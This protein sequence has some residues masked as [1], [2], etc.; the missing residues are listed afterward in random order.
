MSTSLNASAIGA[1]R[2]WPCRLRSVCMHGERHLAAEDPAICLR[3]W[4]PAGK[5]VGVSASPR[6]C[7]WRGSADL[8]GTTGGGGHANWR[9]RVC[10]SSRGLLLA[11]R[12]RL[13]G[14]SGCRSVWLRRPI[15]A[16]IAFID[17]YRAAYGVE[18][19]WRVLPIAPSTYQERAS[20]G[21]RIRHACRRGRGKMW[22][23]SRRS[24]ACSP[25]SSRS[26]ACAK[27]GGRWCARWSGRRDL[28]WASAHYDQ[29]QADTF[30]MLL[31]NRNIPT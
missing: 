1:G 22:P 21:D 6:A 26:A 5:G 8:S 23:S 31:V 19:I 14:M 11:H 24:H 18:P 9:R 4:R 30:S 27:F 3:P 28:R 29:R 13:V 2:L 20:R 15:Q 7:C 12:H 25:R 17:H 10:G 16:M